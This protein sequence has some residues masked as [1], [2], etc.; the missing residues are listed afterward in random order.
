[1][2]LVVNCRS[3]SF[4]CPRGK[5]GQPVGPCELKADLELRN[6]G[7]VPII[8]DN[9][10]A[11]QFDD[12]PDSGLGGEHHPSRLF[13][14][15]PRSQ[16]ILRK[17]GRE[18]PAQ[19]P[20][21]LNPGDHELHWQ[22]QVELDPEY[23][24][25]IEFARRLGTLGRFELTFWYTYRDAESPQASGHSVGRTV[26]GT[27]DEFKRSVLEKWRKFERTEEIWHYRSL[28]EERD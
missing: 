24:N 12:H 8:L 7:S 6:A 10:V 27:F 21:L 14:T 17:T 1:M 4:G 9:V 22:L 2:D 3:V 13:P 16:R 18:I 23:E 19:F 25:S 26:Y 20:F 15:L 5:A 28:S 11:G